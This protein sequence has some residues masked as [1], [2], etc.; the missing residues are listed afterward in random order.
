MKR[1]ICGYQFLLMAT[2]EPERD[3]Q[4]KVREYSPRHASGQELSDAPFCRFAF[5]ADQRRPGVY[6]VVVNDRV[7][8]VGKTNNLSRRF[9]PGEYG[10]IV[11]PEPGNSQVTNRRVNHGILEA[12][13]R[14]DTVGVWFNATSDC[15]EIESTVI[16]RLDLPWNR[17]APSIERDHRP[18]S[19]E[20]ARKRWPSAIRDAETAKAALLRDRRRGEEMFTELLSAY[21]DDGWVFLKRAEAYEQLGSS[22]AAS[23]DYSRAEALLRYPGRKAEARAG[24]LRTRAG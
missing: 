6:A 12:A 17:E 11:V 2:I 22:Q 23:A 18:V 10:H 7:M 20:S 14:G 13:R 3:G 16:G 24:V 21:P 4:G 9:G 8:Y 1:S 5:P 15:D 19:V